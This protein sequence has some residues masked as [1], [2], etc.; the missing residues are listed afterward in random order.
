MMNTV[1]LFQSMIVLSF[2][3]SLGPCDGCMLSNSVVFDKGNIF[4]LFNDS[5]RVF[6]NNRTI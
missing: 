6:K 1:E 4:L 2:F 5:L 3:Q